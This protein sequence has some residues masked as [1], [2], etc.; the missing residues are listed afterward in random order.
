MRSRA[1]KV[2]CRDAIHRFWAAEQL[3]SSNSPYPIPQ[4][5][6]SNLKSNEART[7]DGLISPHRILLHPVANQAS[8]TAAVCRRRLSHSLKQTSTLLAKIRTQ[9]IDRRTLINYL[10]IPSLRRLVPD[11]CT[12]L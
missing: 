4:S 3:A 11:N 2:S 8:P 7:V 5:K 12:A 1:S 9:K 6:I 10:L